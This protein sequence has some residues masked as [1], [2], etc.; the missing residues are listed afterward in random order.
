MTVTVYGGHQEVR[1]GIIIVNFLGS[2]MRGMKM[3]TMSVWLFMMM[4]ELIAE[5]LD[6]IKEE[7]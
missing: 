6:N 2:I 7:S 3:N 1:Y 5:L 4:T